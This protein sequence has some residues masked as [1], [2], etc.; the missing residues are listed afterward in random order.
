M[1]KDWVLFLNKQFL[2]ALYS[3][4]HD[5]HYWLVLTLVCLTNITP[6]ETIIQV[7]F[8]LIYIHPYLQPSSMHNKNDKAS[9]IT[10]NNSHEMR[11]YYLKKCQFTLQNEP[12]L[13]L[14]PDRYFPSTYCAPHIYRADLWGSTLTQQ[15]AGGK[16]RTNHGEDPWANNFDHAHQVIRI[17]T[18]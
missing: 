13:P 17:E 1:R 7:S 8:S 14:M 6:F 11:K 9:K 2:K 4:S 5:F 3:S 12:R 15:H 16:S 18:E 10:L